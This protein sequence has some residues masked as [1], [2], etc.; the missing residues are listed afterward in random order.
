MDQVTILTAFISGLITFFAPCTFVS[1]PAFISYISAETFSDSLEDP[2]SSRKKRVFYSALAYSAGFTV[3]FTILGMTATAVGK[4]FL[5]NKETLKQIG[6][7]LMMIAGTFLL[8]GHRFKFMSFA[9][10]E[11]KFDVKNISKKKLLFPFLIGVT[12]AFAWTPCVGPI[13]GSILFMAGASSETPLHGALLLFI[14]SLGISIPFI[15]F[16]LIFEKSFSIVKKLGRLSRIIYSISGYM[17]I[18]FGASLLFGFYGDISSVV[19]RIFM[20]FGYT[21]R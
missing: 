13:L 9:F 4:T 10:Q 1:L 14:H 12:S 16:A 11:K 18:I 15:I 21:P 19:H 17:I 5:T 8:F 7:F 20:E 3:V 6:G 2:N